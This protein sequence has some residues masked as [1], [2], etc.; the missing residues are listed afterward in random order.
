MSSNQYSKGGQ[1]RTS[2]APCGYTIRKHPREA[3]GI[4]KIHMKRCDTCIKVLDGKKP[5]IPE[6]NKIAGLTN[7]WGGLTIKSNNKHTYMATCCNMETGTSTILGCDS[8]SISNCMETISDKAIEK[9]AVKDA[10]EYME[11]EIERDRKCYWCNARG[12]DGYLMGTG[13]LME[14]VHKDCC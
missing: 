3:N 13:W 12:C 7:G 2:Q 4:M 11:C 1:Y 6:F 10:A 8:N 14:P 5:E 9:R